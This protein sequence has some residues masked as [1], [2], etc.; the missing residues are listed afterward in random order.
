VTSGKKSNNFR[1]VQEVS[2]QGAANQEL[3]NLTSARSLGTAGGELGLRNKRPGFSQEDT[4][5]VC[6]LDT[7]LRPLK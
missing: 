6:E 1:A 7:T 5:R 4:A 3:A 2:P